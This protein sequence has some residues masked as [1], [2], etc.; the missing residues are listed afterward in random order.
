MSKNCVRPTNQLDG[1]ANINLPTPTY[2]SSVLADSTYFAHLKLLFASASHCAAFRD[3]CILG[4]I[5]LRQR[6]FTSDVE[7]GGFGNFE[8]SALMAYLLKVTGAMGGS[9]LGGGYSNYQL[10]KA[11]LQ[12]LST[13]DLSKDPLFLNGSGEKIDG[14][15]I[16][17]LMD[18]ELGLN[19]LF[20]MSPWSY[21]MVIICYHA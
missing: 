16:P 6:G 20:K 14:C 9:I 21:N 11:T 2:N 7:F 1:I 4:R 3:A 13:R 5:W 18:A 10:F 17:V 15:E 8:W 19:L 12:F